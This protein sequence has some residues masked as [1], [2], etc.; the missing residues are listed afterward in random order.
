MWLHLSG[1]KETIFPRRQHWTSS[2]IPAC[3]CISGFFLTRAAN[4]RCDEHHSRGFVY[5]PLSQKRFIFL[6]LRVGVSESAAEELQLFLLLWGASARRGSSQY[7]GHCGSQDQK[8]RQHGCTARFY[9]ALQWVF[10]ALARKRSS[11][12]TAVEGSGP[13]VSVT[14]V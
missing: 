6:H 4:T 11:F 1:E 3:W 7:P 14:D 2:V 13:S 12:T 8:G 5:L 10:S 9:S